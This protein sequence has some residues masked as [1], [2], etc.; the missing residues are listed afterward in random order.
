M[1]MTL[2]RWKLLLPFVK[3]D[4]DLNGRQPVKI[5]LTSVKITLC[6]ELPRFTVRPTAAY[7]CCLGS[8]SN[9]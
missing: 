3:A 1:S 7:Y 4:S 6:C 2:Q 5:L 9:A 8:Y